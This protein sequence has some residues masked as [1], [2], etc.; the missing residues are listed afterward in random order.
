MYNGRTYT[1]T[2]IIPYSTY[3]HYHD[4]PKTQPFEAYV[5]EDSVKYLKD[6]AEVLYGNIK[7]ENFSD[8]Q[9]AEYLL[10]FVQ[11]S[12]QYEPDPKGT[13]MPAYP[14]ETILTGQE[15]CDGKACLFSSLLLVFGI[16]AVLLESK[17][18]LAVG[19]ACT[20]C[21]GTYYP[22][23][24]ARYFYTEPVA[25]TSEI[26]TD[27]HAGDDGHFKILP[28]RQTAIFNR[29]TP[30]TSSNQVTW[31]VDS[32]AYVVN[33][34]SSRPVSDVLVKINGKPFI[35]PQPEV[36]VQELSPNKAESNREDEADPDYDPSY[37]LSQERMIRL[38]IIRKP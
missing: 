33:I 30:L 16:D 27:K 3:K 26:G 9:I 14:V 32:T 35:K 15:D 36:E 29:V 25:A 4:L 6:V 8:Y 34:T 10:A 22:R 19:I 7:D 21:D 37:G 17:H 1:S 13:E 11:Q 38:G 24:N 23:G 2:F 18:H 28:L 31:T 20:K 5:E 12:I